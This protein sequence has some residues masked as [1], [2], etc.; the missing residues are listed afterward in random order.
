[1]RAIY[2][3]KWAES[4]WSALAV[5]EWSGPSQF[6]W[7]VDGAIPKAL[8]CMCRQP[9]NSNRPFLVLVKAFGTRKWPIVS[10]YSVRHYRGRHCRG[11]VVLWRILLYSMAVLSSRAHK[12][13]SREKNKNQVAPAPISSR[14]LCPRPPLLL[15]APNQNRYATQASYGATSDFEIQK[16]L[17]GISLHWGQSTPT[18]RR[19]SEKY[20]RA[21]FTGREVM[22][23]SVC[24]RNWKRFEKKIYTFRNPQKMKDKNAFFFRSEFR[25]F[26]I[27]MTFVAVSDTIGRIRGL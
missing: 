14:F 17:R 7:G 27:V 9:I 13:R 15:S 10:W 18:I 2:D 23:T 6:L 21:P 20:K 22:S 5:Y 16:N 25:A 26:I 1:M 11:Y 3:L 4:N 12:R 24:N 8:R 19:A